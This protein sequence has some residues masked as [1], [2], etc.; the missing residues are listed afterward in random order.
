VLLTAQRTVPITP[1][2]ATTFDHWAVRLAERRGHNRAAIAVANKL[3]RHSW[4]V[5]HY[6]TDF[7]Q[8]RQAHAAA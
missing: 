5:W 7:D 3:A 2:R 6:E 1:L 8:N 4:A